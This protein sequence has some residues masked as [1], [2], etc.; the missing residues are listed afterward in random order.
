[1]G[2]VDSPNVSNTDFCDRCGG[3]AGDG[4]HAQCA[5]ARELEPPRY[6]SSCGRRTVVKVTPRGWSSSC[7]RHG[8]TSTAGA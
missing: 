4:D 7:V 8:T 6:C 3:R 2:F 1:M 5:A